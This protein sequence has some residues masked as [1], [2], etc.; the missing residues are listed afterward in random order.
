[1]LPD[2]E[3]IVESLATEAIRLGA[4]LR[5]AEYL[6]CS[7]TEARKRWIGPRSSGQ[8][9]VVRCRAAGAGE[10]A[11]MMRDKSRLDVPSA[12]RDRTR[13][14]SETEGSARSISAMRDWLDF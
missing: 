11:A 5:E 12:S 4:D 13:R 1:M 2:E 14:S 3:S 7:A 9:W 6:T 10:R 8:R